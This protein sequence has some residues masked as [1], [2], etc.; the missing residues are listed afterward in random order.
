VGSFSSYDRTVKEPL[1]GTP[2]F[3]VL[4]FERSVGLVPHW[5]TAFH[6]NVSPRSAAGRVKLSV[7]LTRF[8]LALSVMTP[9]FT[10]NPFTPVPS[11]AVICTLTKIV[12]LFGFW[13]PNFHV[14]T[15]PTFDS[16]SL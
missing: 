15:P 3:R 2:L 11:V 5:I 13:T 7:M 8:L 4:I 9:L 12:S 16:D 1:V 14:C 10:V 6:V